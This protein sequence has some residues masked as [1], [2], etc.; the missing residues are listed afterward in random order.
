ML[1]IVGRIPFLVSNMVWDV[2]GLG[3]M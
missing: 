2:S 3:K 1:W